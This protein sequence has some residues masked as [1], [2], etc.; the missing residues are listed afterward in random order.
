MTHKEKCE[1]CGIVERLKAR[2]TSLDHDIETTIHLRTAMITDM[3]HGQCEG[4][5]RGLRAWQEWNADLLADA[6]QLLRG[7]ENA[8]E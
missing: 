2:Q 4:Y 8:K 7:A 6:E 1:L 5:L 3:Y